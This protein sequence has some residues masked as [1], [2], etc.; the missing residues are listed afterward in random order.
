MLEQWWKSKTH[1]NVEY[2]Y[3]H[4]S[5]YEC[6]G[7]EYGFYSQV[8]QDMFVAQ[9]LNY[10]TNGTFVD[11]G[12]AHPIKINNTYKL[13]DDLNWSG[14]SID[15]GPPQCVGLPEGSEFEFTSSEYEEFWNKYRKTPIIVGDA[16]EIDYKELFEKYNLPKT[17][18]YL[19]VDIEPPLGTFKALQEVFKTGYKFNVI[20]FET[21]RDSERIC[22]CLEQDS[23]SRFTEYTTPE[24]GY[25]GNEQSREF[26]TSFGYE[27]VSCPCPDTEDWYI[28]KDYIE[29]NPDYN[30]FHK[31][32]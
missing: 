5:S 20:T 1:N 11:I 24:S 16:L 6:V 28:H 29:E 22:I 17:I 10:K 18:D 14:V 15:F 12:A 30:Y 9:V 7:D 4:I 21:E 23:K 2:E 19:T 13:E 32:K 27:R 3:F 25:C 31:H 8:Q 26:I